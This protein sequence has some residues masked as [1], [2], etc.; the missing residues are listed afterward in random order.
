MFIR[1][2]TPQNR[3][4]V[5]HEK[6]LRR[7]KILDRLEKGAQTGDR[8]CT[9][10]G[11]ESITTKKTI[12]L[13]GGKVMKS[14]QLVVKD[15]PSNI[16]SASSMNVQSSKCSSH[17]GNGRDRMEQ[18]HLM[19]ADKDLLSIQVLSEKVYS[20]SKNYS[21]MTL[22]IVP[23]L[24]LN[25]AA[26]PT[27]QKEM[28]SSVRAGEKILQNKNSRDNV[29]CD[30][31]H[32]ADGELPTVLPDISDKETQRRTGFH[33]TS[34]LLSFI[35]IVCNGDLELAGKKST[36]MTWFEEWFFYFE[37][38]WSGMKWNTLEIQYKTAA[39]SLRRVLDEK[40][41]YVL[42]CKDSWPLYASHQEDKQF[43]DNRWN[44]KYPGIRV[45]FWDGTNVNLRYK[46]SAA[47]AESLTYSMY[48]GTNC[49]KGGVGIQKC[50]YIVNRELWTAASDTYYQT[51]CGV[52]SDQE[53]F[54][55]EDLI[56]GKVLPFL[57]VLDKGYRVTAH[58]FRAGG[59]LVQQPHFTN[60]M[61]D[62]STEETLGTA[63]VA[64]N[65]SG[66]ERAV[67]RIKTSKYISNGI[68]KGGS[69]VRMN[70]VWLA[71]GFQVNFMFA[72]VL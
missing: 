17:A 65:R 67:N 72:P 43:C 25:Q 61:Q 35:I 9:L 46:P 53:S 55:N 59:Q 33:S 26:M 31:A 71:Y 51:E 34:A 10:H 29:P 60:A 21:L 69:F 68:E 18:N 15:I 1:S 5:F 24:E 39:S 42:R 13:P 28:L 66:N 4:K 27:A 44:T 48:Y 45:I 30:T 22:S 41:D 3:W 14:V 6:K 36:R 2:L 12:T 8:F 50:G 47:H 32:G 19:K 38:V 40:L 62:F 56:E 23:T 11:L 37:V 58:A 57:N 63:E 20:P 54:Q 64:S 70:K 7:F 49:A 52:F 16:G